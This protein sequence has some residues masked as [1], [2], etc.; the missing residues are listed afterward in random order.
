M[1]V[2]YI[3]KNR[4]DAFKSFLNNRFGLNDF[5]YTLKETD[6]KDLVQF[7]ISQ[8]WLTQRTP[9]TKQLIVELLNAWNNGYS[10]NKTPD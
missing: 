3:L 10:A 7:W 9:S 1:N 6:T 2:G 5:Y 4:T 8:H